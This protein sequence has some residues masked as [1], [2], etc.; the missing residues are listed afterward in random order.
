MLDAREFV[1]KMKA[2]HG[3]ASRIT[4]NR[5]TTSTV[6]P[7]EQDDEEFE[8]GLLRVS[9]TVDHSGMWMATQGFETTGEH[10][11]ILQ[12][13]L[14]EEDHSSEPCALR[15]SARQNAGQHSNPN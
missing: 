1:T 9:P 8:V 13:R 15:R 10:V 5:T 14:D 2:E 4:T 6:L 3:Q 12:D 11:D 7:S